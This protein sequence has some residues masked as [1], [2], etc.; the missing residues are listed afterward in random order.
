MLDCKIRKIHQV[1]GGLDK[2][3]PTVIVSYNQTSVQCYWD[4]IDDNLL[5]YYCGITKSL[6]QILPKDYFCNILN[7]QTIVKS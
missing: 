6:Q 4:F 1:P 2:W 3:G 7:L 5:Q